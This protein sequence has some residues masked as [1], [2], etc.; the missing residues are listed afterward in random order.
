MNQVSVLSASSRISKRRPLWRRVLI[1]HGIKSSH[2]A[3]AMD[4]PLPIQSRNPFTFSRVHMET[5][6]MEGNARVGLHNSVVENTWLG[7]GVA[8]N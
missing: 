8:S 2:L 3:Q 6:N 7:G 5:S 4:S 1:Q